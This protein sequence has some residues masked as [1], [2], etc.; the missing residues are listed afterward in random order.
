[1][2]RSKSI[3]KQHLA[4]PR[5]V[6][7]HRGLYNQ[8]GAYNRNF[9]HVVCMYIRTKD[10][11]CQIVSRVKLNHSIMHKLYSDAYNYTVKCT[12]CV[13]TV[14]SGIWYSLENCTLKIVDVY[15]WS[16][17]KGELSSQSGYY[18]IIR[19]KAECTC[20]PCCR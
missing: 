8:I 3:I 6:I 7:Q 17:L 9:I 13:R 4:L 12:W 18:R 2:C 5:T 1:M 19:N 20:R 15:P 14:N 16:N 10:F 11:S